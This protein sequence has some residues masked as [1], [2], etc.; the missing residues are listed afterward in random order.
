V[1]D[2][3]GTQPRWLQRWLVQGLSIVPMQLAVPLYL[4]RLNAIVVFP[5][6]LS[7]LM[8]KTSR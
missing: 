3:T 6:L 8:L 7:V 1:L 2:L 4:V 5:L